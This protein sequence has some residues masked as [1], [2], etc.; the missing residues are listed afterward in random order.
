MGIFQKPKRIFCL[1]VKNNRQI[2]DLPLAIKDKYLVDEKRGRAWGI[3]SNSLLTFKGKQC[4][5]LTENTCKPICFNGNGWKLDDFQD[6]VSESYGLQLLRMEKETK[7][8]RREHLIL[9]MCLALVV[10]IAFLVVAGLLQSG[11]VHI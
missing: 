9:T 5:L 10:M 7:Q 1:L 2:D 4:E 8:E 3:S 11:S 6:V